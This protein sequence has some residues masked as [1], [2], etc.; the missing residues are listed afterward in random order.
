MSNYR[1]V[2]VATQPAGAAACVI[3]ADS[4]DMAYELGNELL[5]ES[6]FPTIEVWRARE[7]I[8]RMCKLGPDTATAGA[9]SVTGG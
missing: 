2:L 7:L 3:E 1:F 8:Y 9:K 5:W 4:D 6:D